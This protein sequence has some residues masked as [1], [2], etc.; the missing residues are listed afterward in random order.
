MATLRRVVERPRM[1][2]PAYRIRRDCG[3]RCPKTA[4]PKLVVTKGNRPAAKRVVA[5]RV[6]GKLRPGS[7]MD[8]ANQ[9]VFAR[10]AAQHR[11][12]L[13]KEHRRDGEGCEEWQSRWKEWSDAVRNAK[14]VKP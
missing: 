11:A 13:A 3:G 8:A 9:R 6:V 14:R 12:A 1:Q 4:V 5:R 7:G 10:L 2:P